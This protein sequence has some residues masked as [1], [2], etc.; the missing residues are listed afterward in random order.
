MGSQVTS[1][2]IPVWSGHKSLISDVP[3][4]SELDHLILRPGELHIVLA[5]LRTIGALIDNSGIDICWPESELYGPATVK[6]IKQGNHVERGEIAHSITLQVLFII[7]Q[8]RWFQGDA[9]SYHR[10]EQVAKELSQACTD[11]E[12]ADVKKVNAKRM[13]TIES[14]GI[15]EKMEAFGDAHA[16]SLI[17]MVMRQCMRM[18]MEVLDFIKSVRTEDFAPS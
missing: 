16:N 10:L 3:H 15:V 2:K 9:I 8:E 18:V 4:Q 7:Y 6:Q 12:K 11:R 13:E 14:L 1:S 5:Q 17:F